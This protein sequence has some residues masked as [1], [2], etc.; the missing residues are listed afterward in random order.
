MVHGGAILLATQ[1]PNVVPRYA[2]QNLGAPDAVVSSRR[3]VLMVRGEELK[4][5]TCGRS[6]LLNRR[7]Y[8]N[9]E[10]KA[11]IPG[12]AKIAHK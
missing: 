7:Y 1:Q 3:S 8:I 10:F 9:S 2:P 12:V 11:W 6:R 4:E 5:T